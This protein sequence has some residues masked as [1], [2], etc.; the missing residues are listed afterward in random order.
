[1]LAHLIA[2]GVAQEWMD[3]EDAAEAAR[4]IPYTLE[5]L[6]S[7]RA[8]NGY[9][10]RAGGQGDCIHHRHFGNGSKIRHGTTMLCFPYRPVKICA[11]KL[12]TGVQVKF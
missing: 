12:Y 11:A 4:N 10:R 1:M 8:R 5:G 9:D 3:C 7:I 6:K 2:E